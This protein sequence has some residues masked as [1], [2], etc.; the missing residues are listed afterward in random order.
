[1][2][3]VL[4]SH[5]SEWVPPSKIDQIITKKRGV[6]HTFKEVVEF[7][8]MC[9][10]AEMPPKTFIVIPAVRRKNDYG[11]SNFLDEEYVLNKGAQQYIEE[12]VQQEGCKRVREVQLM[13]RNEFQNELEGKSENE[14]RRSVAPK[15]E[16]QEE[17]F[18][19]MHFEIE[20]MGNW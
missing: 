15:Q 5:V 12:F 20:E 18:G 3:K 19:A 17:N 6:F 11:D 13:L 1:M 10:D 7:F 4:I 8:G 9:K 16:K 14:R 2:N